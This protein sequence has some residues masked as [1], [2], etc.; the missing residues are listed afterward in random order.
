MLQHPCLRDIFRSHE[1]PLPV[2]L[3]VSFRNR[4]NLF[5]QVPGG[6]DEIPSP[7][8]VVGHKPT[9]RRD[10]RTSGTEFSE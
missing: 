3:E 5:G 6:V 10:L 4:A 7:I 9:W 1:H 2:F 8:S